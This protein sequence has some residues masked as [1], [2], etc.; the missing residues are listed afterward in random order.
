MECGSGFA[1]PSLHHAGVSQV[2]HHGATDVWGTDREEWTDEI[3]R[4]G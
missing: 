3:L 1:V 4:Y 2:A